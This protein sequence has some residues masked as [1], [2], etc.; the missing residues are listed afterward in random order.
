MIIIKTYRACDVYKSH[1]YL[2]QYNDD[3]FK[4]LLNKYQK[5]KGFEKITKINPYKQIED[6]MCGTNETITTKEELE[7]QSLSRTKRNI[8]EL[9]LCNNFEYFATVTIASS[10]CDRYSLIECQKKFK[11]KLQTIKKYNRKFKYLFIT[12]KHKDGA[13]HFHGLVANIPLITNNYG[14]FS[15]P[16]LNKLG[17]N[18]FSKIIDYNKCCNYITKYITKDCI[19]NEHNQI[20]ISSRGL[21]KAD[22]YEIPCLDLEWSFENDFCKIKE[23]S[24]SEL[25]KNDVFQI[26]GLYNPKEFEKNHK[27]LE[28]F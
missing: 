13:F 6:F 7:R 14:Y 9:A 20:Y 19:R 22:K 10:S 28:E 1:C 12:E 3:Y 17:F 24:S 2:V 26:L 21:K 16:T 5:E 23:F 11:C 18:S 4:I 8:K 15:N 27:F 25:S